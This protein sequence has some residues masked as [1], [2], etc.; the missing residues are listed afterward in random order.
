METIENT[1]ATPSATATPAKATPSE[2]TPAKA[3]PAKQAKQAPESFRVLGS[4]VAIV[5]LEKILGDLHSDAVRISKL[6]L[7]NGFGR[8]V[9]SIA[10]TALK[11][12]NLPAVREMARLGYL[13]PISDKA[14]KDKVAARVAKIVALNSFVDSLQTFGLIRRQV[15]N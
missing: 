4:K 8:D 13:G 1:V 5:D 11:I 2:A 3:T 9:K 14:G 15:E 6:A 12:V 10:G 7:E